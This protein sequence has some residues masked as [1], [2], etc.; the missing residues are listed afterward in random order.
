MLSALLARK[1][2]AVVKELREGPARSQQEAIDWV[3]DATGESTD[4]I[5][6]RVRKANRK[7]HT[8][9]DAYVDNVL[10]IY[11]EKIPIY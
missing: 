11:G 8:F 10:E 9:N 7:P 2:L 1:T 4:T 5:V 6:S 3:A